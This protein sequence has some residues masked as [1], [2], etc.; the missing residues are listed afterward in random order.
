MPVTVPIERSPSSVEAGLSYAS[1]LDHKAESASPGAY[2]VKLDNGVKVD[3]GA[4][5]RT[6]VGR[7]AF[8]AGKPAHVLFR[9]SD[10]EVGS[11]ASTIT[12]DPST[13]HSSGL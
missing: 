7:F 5:D 6:A 12:I 10:S 1:L 8:P 9:P 4:T 3:L 11:T 13:R 2:S